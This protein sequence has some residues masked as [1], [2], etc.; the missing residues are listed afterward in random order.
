MPNTYHRQDVSTSIASRDATGDTVVIQQGGR[1]ASMGGS[2]THPIQILVT[3]GNQP[4]QRTSKYLYA[5]V[6]AVPVVTEEWIQSCW[7]LHR[8][9]PLPEQQQTEPHEVFKNCRVYLAGPDLASSSLAEM[10]QHAGGSF[11]P[12]SLRTLKVL[13]MCLQVLVKL[14]RWCSMLGG[15]HTCPCNVAFQLS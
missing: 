5:K 1:R 11:D 6:R 12:V 9:M 14:L 4:L 7:A 10:I 15:L 8:L 2:G 3:P 13:A